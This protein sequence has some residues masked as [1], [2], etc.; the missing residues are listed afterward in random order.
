MQKHSWEVLLIEDDEDDYLLTRDTL[1]QARGEKF[2]LSWASSY[3]KGQQMLREKTFDAILTDYRLGVHTGLD[4]IGEATALGVRA[5]IIFLTGRGNYEIDVEAMNSGAA[6]YMAKSEVTPR[7]L[8]RAIRYAIL[9]RQDEEALRAAKEELEQRVRERTLELV[10]K[11]ESLLVEIQERRR[12]EKELAEMQSRLLDR[13]EAERIVLARDLHDIPM[14]DLYGVIFL[15]DGLEMEENA[16]KE[17]KERLLQ[18]V[19]SLRTISRDLR[20]PA[21]APYGLEKAIQSHLEML[22]Q[23]HP[24][25]TIHTELFPD[26]QSLPELVRMALF[27]IYQVAVTNVI[28]HAQATE[29]TVRLRL[30]VD[31]VVLEIQDNG[32]GFDVPQRWIE[33]AR[34]GH[35]G[36][37]GAAE[38]AE[39]IGGKLHVESQANLGSLIRVTTP[40][41]IHV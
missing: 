6:D 16:A 27:R 25:L 9:R 19:S 13:V 11:N 35:L 30:S 38:R 32:C 1:S 4:L 37:V 21:L 2:T 12:V 10:Q 15:L 39:A 40:Y 14:Q 31:E 28:R 7:L 5:P 24:E 17:V 36:L 23:N 34:G 22:R 29:V 3:A 18:V 33:M 20:P 41:P 26:G 8:E